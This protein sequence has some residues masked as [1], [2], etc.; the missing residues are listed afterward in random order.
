MPE[1]LIEFGPWLRVVGLGVGGLLVLW[2]GWALLGRLLRR[3]QAIPEISL[4]EALADIPP[5]PPL[6]G[7]RQLRVEGVPVRLRLVVLAP[8][9]RTRPW[10]LEMLDQVVPGLFDL[11]RREQPRIRIWPAQLSY[12]GFARQFFA[13]AYPPEPAGAPTPWVLLA[14]RVRT[15]NTQMML[16]LA[17]LA[18][19]PT[20]LGNRVLD[21]HQWPEVLRV[22]VRE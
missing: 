5:P 18:S 12:E 15:G 17:L 14:G 19:K 1:A 10:P 20:T 22:R 13:N 6:T 7:D 4:A 9:G 8:T 11:V 3:R 16:G 21:A 2:L